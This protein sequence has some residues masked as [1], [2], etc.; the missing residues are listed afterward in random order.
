MC[1]LSINWR[2]STF[3][4]F[5][6]V[7]N[8][9]PI[10]TSSIHQPV[11]SYYDVTMTDYSHGFLWIQGVEVRELRRFVKYARYIHVCDAK[12]GNMRTMHGF[13]AALIR[14]LVFLHSRIHKTWQY[15]MLPLPSY[16]IFNKLPLETLLLRMHIIHGGGGGGGGGSGYCLAP[17]TKS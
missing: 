8:W 10:V 14:T 3:Y 1:F 17:F 2:K 4:S 7:R 9:L 12:R 13:G 16:Q 5:Q 15:E 6:N 11:A